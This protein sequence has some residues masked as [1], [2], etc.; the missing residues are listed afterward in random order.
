MQ[1]VLAEAV[2]RKRAELAPRVAELM[3][4]VPGNVPVKPD[5]QRARFWQTDPK[6]T[7]ER[8]AE[9]WAKGLSPQDIGLLKYPYREVD[10]KANGRVTKRVQA[11]YMQEMAALGPPEPQGIELAAQ[12]FEMQGG[13]PQAQ[14]SLGLGA[15]MPAPVMA[16][17]P[18]PIPPP[19]APPMLPPMEGFV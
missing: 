10:A 4:P 18:A 7:P 19:V 5:E 8:E 15:T 12:Q 16:P 6:W 11:R 9:L 14:P 17:P 13:G 2:N 1:T 3:R